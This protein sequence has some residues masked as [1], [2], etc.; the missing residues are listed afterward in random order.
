LQRSML[1][2]N[3]IAGWAALT[4]AAPRWVQAHSSAV[5]PMGRTAAGVGRSGRSDAEKALT[6][7]CTYWRVCDPLATDGGHFA[8]N[9]GAVCH[10]RIMTTV[11][12]EE[13]SAF[14]AGIG[15]VDDGGFREQISHSVHWGD[16]E[17]LWRMSTER[18]LS[19]AI[20]SLV[21][22]LVLYRNHGAAAPIHGAVV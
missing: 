12:H 4:D 1:A 8:F 3:L 18:V 6:G 16:R 2:L 14:N 11:S 22:L 7:D 21:T 17:S 13:R 15:C 5:L 19:H 10:H 9:A 20:R